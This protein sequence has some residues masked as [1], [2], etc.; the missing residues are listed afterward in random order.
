MNRPF[1]VLMEYIPG[2][3]VSSM[4]RDRA[5]AVFHPDALQR[6]KAD[7]AAKGWDAAAEQQIKDLRVGI[8]DEYPR[9]S[10]GYDKLRYREAFESPLV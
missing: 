7:A 6:K 9:E 1:V 5:R 10:A 4:G 2:F 8:L 3:A